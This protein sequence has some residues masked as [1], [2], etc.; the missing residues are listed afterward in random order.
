VCLCGTL[1]LEIP[2]AVAVTKYSQNRRST[3][4]GMYTAL[5]LRL[6]VGLLTLLSYIG[7]LYVCEQIQNGKTQFTQIL[8]YNACLVGL[9]DKSEI[10]VLRCV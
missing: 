6:H 5:V 8:I 10:R 7:S 2:V 9:S 1:N 4:D 3:V